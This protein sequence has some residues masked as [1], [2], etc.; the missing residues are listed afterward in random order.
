MKKGLLIV[1]SGPS[2]A[3]KGTVMGKLLE[4]G[5]YALQQLENLEREK[6]TVSHISSRQRKNLN[7]LLLTKDC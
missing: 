5:K 4:T 7:S 3:G 1:V 2:G 6:L